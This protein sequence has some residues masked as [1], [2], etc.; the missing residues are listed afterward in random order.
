MSEYR[1]KTTVLPDGE[2]L[3]VLIGR[4]GLPIFSPTAYAVSELRGRNLAL[5][6]I[7]N[8]LR[9]LIVLQMFLESHDGG[10]QLS[11][12]LAEGRVLSIA[13]IESLAQSC[14]LP[15]EQFRAQLNDDNSA[16]RA[17]SINM[18]SYRRRVSAA[19]QERISPQVA[20][21]RL[22]E[23]RDYLA[24]LVTVQASDPKTSDEVRQK[25]AAS[26]RVAFNA[27]S[28]R[29]PR[30]RH[31]FGGLEREGLDDEPVALL[32]AVTSPEYPD[33][34]W[35]DPHAR[36]RN[37]LIVRWLH[38]LGL[39][40]GELLNVRIPDVDFGREVVAIVRRPDDV[41]D[42]RRYQPCVKTRA[43]VLPLKPHLLDETRRYILEY[44]RQNQAARKH[45]FL[46]VAENG[47]P[48]SIPAFSKVFNV[49]RKKHPE[50][51]R[52][53]TGHVLRHT[54][55][56]RYS[57]E[58]DVQGVPEDIE[59]KTRSYLMGWSPTSEMATTYTRRHIREK[60]QKASTQL[61]QRLTKGRQSDD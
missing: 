4:D 51:P 9:S 37:A 18:E 30:T 10:I 52:K 11:E 3:A 53:L 26:S 25:L 45:D 42:S 50:L 41:M 27:I 16:Q 43:R 7:S 38:F 2:R 22:Q 1:V 33:N 60:A 19:A 28:A 29:I 44:R 8:S 32:L 5:A 12:R 31:A 14:R 57:R 40:R 6:S 24:W 61:Q 20:G 34:P 46:F 13:E 58:M 36:Q 21:T 17:T 55:N 48:L 15:I 54:W 59:K 49:I 35:A 23:I 47:A 56:D 39:R